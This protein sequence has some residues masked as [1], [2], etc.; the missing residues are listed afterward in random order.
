MMSASNFQWLL[1]AVIHARQK[2]TLSR[3]AGVGSRL[4]V[5]GVILEI[6]AGFAFIDHLLGVKIPD[7]GP[8]MPALF[9]GAMLCVSIFRMS[10]PKLYLDWVIV[11]VIYVG[12]GCILSSNSTVLTST[13]SFIFFCAFFFAS[14]LMRIWIALTYALKGKKRTWLMTGGLAGLLCMISIVFARITGINVNYDI[15]LATDLM[16]HGLSVAGYGMSIREE[17]A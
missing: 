14:T 2:R 6:M 15:A 16:F 9:G 8:G 4:V 17:T 1:Y 3:F 10:Y 12:L 11:G 13:L 7:Y 5:L